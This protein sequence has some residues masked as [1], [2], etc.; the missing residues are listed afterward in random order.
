MIVVDV[1]GEIT[2]K[3]GEAK[4][5]DRVFIDVANARLNSELV[6]KQWPMKSG[7]LQQIR[8]GQYDNTT[9]RVVLD[10][11]TVGSVASFSLRDPDRLVIDILGQGARNGRDFRRNRRSCGSGNPCAAAQRPRHPSLSR[12]RLP[13]RPPRNQSA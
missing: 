10:L 6:G 8:V 5:P 11:G 9:V 2:F 3:Q 7:V 12:R 4:N 1:S 13:K